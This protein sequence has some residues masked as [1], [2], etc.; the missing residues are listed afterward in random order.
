MWSDAAS[1]QGL[2]NVALYVPLA[3]FGV[4]AFSRPLTNLAACVVLSGATE[5]TQTLAGTGRACDAADFVDNS[6]GALIG[7][8][9]AVL[10]LLL[11]GWRR[12]AASRR[13]ALGGVGVLLLGLA[14]VVAVAHFSIHVVRPARPGFS[15]AE[16]APVQVAQPIAT[17]LFGPRAHVLHTS[18]SSPTPD[19]PQ[20]VLSVDTDQGTFQ[21]QWPNGRLVAAK[22]ADQMDD[23]GSLTENQ[24]VD[25]GAAFAAQWFPQVVADS[26]RTVTPVGRTG[27]ARL[28][29]YR[30]YADGVLM[31][32]R[33]DI[34]VSSSGRLLAASSRL[35]ED[36]RLPHATVAM[37]AARSAAGAAHPGSRTDVAFLLAKQVG[38]QWRPCWAVNLIDPGKASAT[39]S[40]AYVDAVTGEVLPADQG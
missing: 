4:L 6:L 32:L 33:L 12:A 39:G 29:S 7:T 30:R 19:S 34:T 38:G 11:T 3:F 28:L 18:L 31:P 5:I 23:H 15:R 14:A 22:S 36:P 21:T 2:M 25:S 8:A 16:D 1:E 13:D 40:V 35:V 10:L 24:L 37:D 26:T 20:Q 27:E 17:K 9:G